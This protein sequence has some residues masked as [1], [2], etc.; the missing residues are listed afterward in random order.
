MALQDYFESPIAYNPDADVLVT[1][2]T[3]QVFAVDDVG[4]ATPLTV[5]EPTSGAVIPTLSSSSI[6]VL[7]SFRVAGDP[8]QIILKSGSFATLLSSRYG[9]LAEAGFDPEAVALA[10]AAGPE[11][12][13]ARDAAV[14]AQAAVE[15]DDAGLDV[16]RPML[17]DI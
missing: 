14:A 7:P 3:F 6:G 13:A 15:A 5:T 10:V 9:A 1:G 12:V 2:A 17:V 11:A 8:G 4:F 16:I